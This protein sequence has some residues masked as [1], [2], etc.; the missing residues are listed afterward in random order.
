MKTRTVWR[1]FGIFSLVATAMLAVGLT[2]GIRDIIHPTPVSWKAD[3][4]GESSGVHK[5][6]HK[7]QITALGDSLTRGTGDE[8]GLGYAGN[9]RIRLAENTKQ[10][11]YVYNNGVNGYKAANLLKDL[12]TKPD[13]RRQVQQA[14]MIVL[15]IG[16]NDLFYTQSDEVKPDVIRTRIP[17]A[18]TNYKAI[19]SIVTELNPKA[20]LLYMGLYNP[21]PDLPNAKESAKVVQE[22]NNGV[23]QV[24]YEYPQAIFVPTDDLFRSDGMKYISSDHFHPNQA[25]YKRIGERMA[26]VLK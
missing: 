25:G 6:S 4:T 15:S 11:V 7:L 23:T 1:L 2:L 18:L 20:K 12:R 3:Q 8:S 9:L 22:W 16:G 19:V 24:L 5:T 10:E 21:F 26:D 13:I 14:D 17:A